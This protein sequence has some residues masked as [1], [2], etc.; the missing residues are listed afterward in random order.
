MLRVGI[1]EITAWAIAE[2]SA[3]PMAGF[4]RRATGSRRPARATMRSILVGVAQVL[5]FVA[6]NANFGH[7]D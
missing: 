5:L 6:C 4:A 7:L 2:A 3:E 1:E